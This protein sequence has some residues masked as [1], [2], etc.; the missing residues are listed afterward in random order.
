MAERKWLQYLGGR[1]AR[2]SFDALD[3]KKGGRRETSWSPEELFHR[4]R[5]HSGLGSPQSF[6]SNDTSTYSRSR[7]SAPHLTDE[8]IDATIAAATQRAEPTWH[9]PS[10]D[11]IVEALHA[12]VMQKR[13]DLDSL[14]PQYNWHVMV[15]LEAYGKLRYQLEIVRQELADLVCLREQE[16]ERFGKLAEE[17][18]TREESFRAEI[19]RMELV[20]SRSSVDGL[21]K[22]ML[23]RSHSLVARS[24]RFP[25]QLRPKKASDT[26]GR[27]GDGSES[28]AARQIVGHQERGLLR[29]RSSQQT[30]ENI[31]TGAFPD[32]NH[33]AE[34]SQELE[35]LGP[36]S[37]SWFEHQVS[38]PLS[39]AVQS[40]NP[41][42]SKSG[43]LL[44]SRCSEHPSFES[45]A[46]SAE[47]YYS[48]IPHHNFQGLD[49]STSA[50]S[51]DSGSEPSQ[52]RIKRIAWH[53]S[54]ATD[55]LQRST[56]AQRIDPK[57]HHIATTRLGYVPTLQFAGYGNL[58]SFSQLE[59]DIESGKPIGGTEKDCVI[60]QGPP[61]QRRRHNRNF[62]FRTGQDDAF[63]TVRTSPA[64]SG[65]VPNDTASVAGTSV[66]SLLAEHHYLSK[67]ILSPTSTPSAKDD[68]GEEHTGSYSDGTGKDIGFVSEQV[69]VP[70]DLIQCHDN[71]LTEDPFSHSTSTGTIKYIGGEGTSPSVPGLGG[72]VISNDFVRQSSEGSVAE[73][74]DES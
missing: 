58:D 59:H 12:T 62:S 67:L 17:W 70:R 47:H 49:S 54:R 24:R 69:H 2:S 48:R 42:S 38:R 65:K 26:Q 13:D 25:S 23:A 57:G 8:E 4:R 55:Y 63:F 44:S 31:W 15:L 45:K 66:G 16:Q 9:N 34:L 51:T 5:N 14:P 40:T 41:N 11:K 46:P 74:S 68:K 52:P 61:R 10:I 36:D 37:Q 30:L 53:P 6:S 56:Q 71:V 33:D 1:R 39:L 60:L 19:K 64:G 29:V 28:P 35:R 20:L 73:H 27:Y 22:V 43:S 18:A 72:G 3:A 50:S 7:G 21:E 32:S